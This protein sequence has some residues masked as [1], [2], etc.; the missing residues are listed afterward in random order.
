IAMPINLTIGDN[1]GGDN[2]DLVQYGSAAGTEQIGGVTVTVQSSGFLDLATNSKTDTILALT[3]F[4]GPATS[5]DVTTGSGT[6]TLGG[7]LTLLDQGGLTTAAPAATLGGI[8]NINAPSGANGGRFFVIHD[9][10]AAVELNVLAADYNG[11]VNKQGAG[12]V[13]FSG[14]NAYAGSTVIQE[15]ELVAATNDALGSGAEVQALTF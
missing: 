3:L 12:T 1:R 11:D 5:G 6:L 9:S 13:V 14:A 8:L 4:D 2:A 10:P 7:N 15:G